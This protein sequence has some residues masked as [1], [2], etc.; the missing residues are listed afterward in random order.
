MKLINVSLVIS[1]ALCLISS[2]NGDDQSKTLS[3][4]K[5]S[6]LIQSDNDDKNMVP[7]I[8]SV[9]KSKTETEPSIDFRKFG[10]SQSFSDYLNQ[11]YSSSFFIHGFMA[12]LAVIIVSELGDKT[13]FIAAILA[14]SNNKLTVGKRTDLM[15]E[16]FIRRFSLERYPHWR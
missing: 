7:N 16:F 14:M 5:L 9:E 13:F 8:A 12:S 15:R 10:L 11:L 1:L 6:N 3:E 4:N 2:T